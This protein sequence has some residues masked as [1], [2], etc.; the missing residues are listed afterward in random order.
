MRSLVRLVLISCLGACGGQADDAPPGGADPRL[1]PGGG[2]ADAPIDG[3]LHVHVVEPDSDR[4][5][6]GATVTIASGTAKT[7]ATGLATFQFVDGPQTITASAPNRAAATWV[8]VTGANVTVPLQPQRVPMVRVSGRLASQLAPPTQLLHYNLA[9]VLYSFLDD[10]SAP[11]N[12]IPQPMNGSMPLFTCINSNLGG[13]PVTCNW[14]IHARV[15]KQIHTAVIVDGD[16]KGTTS[17]DDDTYTLIG[18]A[19]GDVMTLTEGQ[20]VTGEVL[21]M[22]TGT[23][24]LSVTF[25]APSPGLPNAVAIPE[26]QL[27]DGAGRIVFPLPTLTAAAGSKQVLAP[28]GKF[29]GTYEIVA[30]ATPSATADAPFSTSFVHGVSGAATL[31]AWLSPPSIRTAAAGF[32]F[33]AS[34]GAAFHTA[35]FVRDG[36]TLWNVT[37]L[38]GS[39]SFTRPTPDPLGGGTATYTVTAADAPGFDPASFEIT[40]LKARLARAAGAEASL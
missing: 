19:A 23:Q 35:Q 10:P 37:L 15:G 28:T 33:D 39:T 24:A 40:S 14:Q 36:A 9:V 30:L 22:V 16:S 4:P 26:L 21:T 3:L 5:I 29:A 1:I 32:A 20:D 31:P 7:D 34:P 17:P 38:D 13:S 12:S 27:A 6:A 8:G 11:E 18:Y 25:P 2:V